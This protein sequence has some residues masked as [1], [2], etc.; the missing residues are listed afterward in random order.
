MNNNMKDNQ[1]HCLEKFTKETRMT[2]DCGYQQ[3]NEIGVGN[4]D[5]RGEGGPNGSRGRI[6][7][8]EGIYDLK[9]GPL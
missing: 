9:D 1:K 8:R 6:Y 4:H 5:V 3:L 7:Y 2:N